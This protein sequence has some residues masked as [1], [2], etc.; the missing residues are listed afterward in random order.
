MLAQR[1]SH[2]PENQA[3]PL[4]YSASHNALVRGEVARNPTTPQEVL[5]TLTGDF[6][7][8]VRSDA[9]ANP[10][11][12]ADA[13]AA[14]ASDPSQPRLLRATAAAHP[15]PPAHLLPE[16]ALTDDRY[17]RERLASRPDLDETT[18]TLL[19]LGDVPRLRSRY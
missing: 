15:N 4:A 2:D 16:L 10:A 12:P 5:A 11:T 3:A 13:I 1:R 19:A 18:K 17:L 6:D 9:I 14:I 7:F 8:S